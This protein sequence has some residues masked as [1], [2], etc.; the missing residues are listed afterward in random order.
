LDIASFVFTRKPYD[1]AADIP[2]GVD[3]RGWHAE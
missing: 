1:R 3:Q 2:G